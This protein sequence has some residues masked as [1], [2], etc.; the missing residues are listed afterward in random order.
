MTKGHCD[1]LKYPTNDPL[2][3][4]PYQACLP[5][6]Q[7][8][9]GVGKSYLRL[10]EQA[11]QVLFRHRAFQLVLFQADV[12]AGHIHID[13][14]LLLCHF[15]RRMSQERLCPRGSGMQVPAALAQVVAVIIRGILCVLSERSRPSVFGQDGYEQ[16]IPVQLQP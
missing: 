14:G 5:L 1:P 15:V 9:N 10:V 13:A 2:S 11:E 6:E 4:L 12:V 7:G 3:Q 8:I 16:V